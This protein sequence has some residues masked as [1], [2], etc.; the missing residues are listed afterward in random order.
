MV[1]ITT[2]FSF[3]MLL[4]LST[5]SGVE[6]ALRLGGLKMDCFLLSTMVDIICPTPWIDRRTFFPAEA[7]TELMWREERGEKTDGRTHF[8]CKCSC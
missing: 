7:A 2:M 4:P 8:E 6:P 1:S 5:G 3:S